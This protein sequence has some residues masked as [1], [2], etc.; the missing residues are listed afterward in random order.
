MVLAAIALY[1]ALAL[2][3][4][5]Q[6]HRTVLPVLRWGGNTI[7]AQGSSAGRTDL[8]SREPGVRREL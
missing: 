6:R 3:L 2:E 1:A 8:L 4:E 7:A 5:G